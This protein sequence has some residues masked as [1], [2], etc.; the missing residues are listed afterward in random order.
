M[1]LLLKACQFYQALTSAGLDAALIR[2]SQ[3][4]HFINGAADRTSIWSP[5]VI[6]SFAASTPGAA[7]QFFSAP[8]LRHVERVLH[9]HEH[10]VIQ[11]DFVRHQPAVVADKQPIAMKGADAVVRMGAQHAQDVATLHGLPPPAG[12]TA[13][14][15]LTSPA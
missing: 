5:Q 2:L 13:A 4:G 7:A 12:G 10:H 8:G 3:E 9:L 11:H 6:L 14:G 15:H 1:F